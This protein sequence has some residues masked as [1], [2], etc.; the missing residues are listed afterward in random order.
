MYIQFRK[1]NFKI[2]IRMNYKYTPFNVFSVIIFIPRI[3][4]MIAS[5]YEINI[6]RF[7]LIL[8]SLILWL[9]DYFMQIKQIKYVQIFTIEIIIIFILVLYFIN[10]LINL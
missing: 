4:D 9:V 6:L 10:G 1:S 5:I 7:L 8:I 2:W 3:V